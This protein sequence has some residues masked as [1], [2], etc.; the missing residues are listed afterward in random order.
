MDSRWYVPH[1]V[2]GIVLIGVAVS[3]LVLRDYA[4]AGVVAIAVLGLVSIGAAR[5][6]QA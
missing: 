6:R 1:R 4:T 5:R 3:M 2:V